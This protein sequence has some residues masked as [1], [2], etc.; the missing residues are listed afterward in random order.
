MSKV[1]AQAATQRIHVWSMNEHLIG[2][3]RESN[4]RAMQSLIS[5]R[6]PFDRRASHQSRRSRNGSA[7][8]GSK[9]RK[10]YC[11][12]S[13]TFAALAAWPN[14]HA[15]SRSA[16]RVRERL[17]SVRRDRTVDLFRS[18]P[19][20]SPEF[21]RLT[22]F[23]GLFSMELGPA[24]RDRRPRTFEVAAD[25]ECRLSPQRLRR[26]AHY[27]REMPRLIR[28]RST[29]QHHR[30]SHRG[31]VDQPMRVAAAVCA[32]GERRSCT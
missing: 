21:R 2:L 7:P 20:I 17:E 22:T 32:A 4:G 29:R 15:A 11:G 23:G 30:Q 25:V 16:C 6:P 14:L 10:G 26:L 8:S 24:E 5:A 12:L 27:W 28:S 18:P 3:E 31:I 9:D 1:A 19:E 13:G